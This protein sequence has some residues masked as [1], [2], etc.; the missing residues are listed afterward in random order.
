MTQHR[1]GRTGAEPV[2][3]IDLRRRRA[4]RVHQR[5]HLAA[6]ACATNPADQTN[7]RVHQLLKTEALRQ[8]RDQ[9]QPGISDQVRVIKG[10]VDPVERVRYSRHW[11]CLLVLSNEMA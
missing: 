1:T 9:Q 10:R 8:R 5:Q 7:R 4:H 11:K 6:R 3:V 2:G